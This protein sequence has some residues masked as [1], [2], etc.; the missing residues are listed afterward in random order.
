MKLF[1]NMQPPPQRM[2]ANKRVQSW[3]FERMDAIVPTHPSVSD[4]FLVYRLVAQLQVIVW[5]DVNHENKMF[6]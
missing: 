3:Q 4:F 1:P 5:I 2:H 6:S